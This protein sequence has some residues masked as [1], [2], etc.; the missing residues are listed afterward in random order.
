V[1]HARRIKF[2]VVESEGKLPIMS[3]SKFQFNQVPGFE[4]DQIFSACFWVSGQLGIC[5]TKIAGFLPAKFY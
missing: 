2:S 3:V 4:H 1:N 5:R